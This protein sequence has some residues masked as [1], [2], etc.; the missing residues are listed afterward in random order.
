MWIYTHVCDIFLFI[1]ILYVQV[2][3]EKQELNNL[4]LFELIKSLQKFGDA[5]CLI[6][7]KPY[8]FPIS[9]S[10]IKEIKIVMKNTLERIL[11][12][13]FGQRK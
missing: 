9:T 10:Y 11:R 1:Q 6:L 5:I 4:E 13:C 12:F 3:L 7:S 8:Y 2:S